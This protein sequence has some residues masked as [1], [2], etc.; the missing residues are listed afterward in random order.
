MQV[1]D[2]TENQKQNIK[3]IC[4]SVPTHLKSFLKGNIPTLED[5][6]KKTNST[7]RKQAKKGVTM[8]E[9]YM[10]SKDYL[11][12]L[13]VYAS[14]PGRIQSVC[15]RLRVLKKLR[16]KHVV[17]FGAGMGIDSICYASNGLRVINVEFDNPSTEFANYLIRKLGLESRII[18][19]LPETFWNY[20]NSRKELWDAVQAIE[21]V[22]H[23]EDPHTTRNI[24][25]LY[26]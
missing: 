18:H 5:A 24:L 21:V 11:I 3:E 15:K 22:A 10:G 23:V 26:Q 9:F 14:N 20:T 25:E 1:K 4:K 19:I 8:E 6:R 13:A 2:L 12:E 17:D 7:F 16:A